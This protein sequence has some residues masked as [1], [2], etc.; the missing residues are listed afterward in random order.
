M[1]IKLPLNKLEKRPS[2][3]IAVGYKELYDDFD[4][5]NPLD[6]IKEI[7]T[8]AIIKFV[9]EHY[10]KGMY[11][12]ADARRQRRD[13]MD[14]RRYL[15]VKSKK[16]LNTYVKQWE[17]QGNHVFL[18]GHEGCMMLYRL[19]LQNNVPL[20]T[21]DDY[22]DLCEDEHEPV[23]KAL[24]YCNQIWTDCQLDE[25]DKAFGVTVR[26]AASMVSASM[27]IPHSRKSGISAL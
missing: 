26:L 5:V 18:F 17:S 15:P 4:T 24:L 14:M 20:D 10:A 23:Y 6:L 13:V 19:A 8:V 22:V 2:L 16:R 1:P 21:D 7:P 3:F 9:A 27:T 25:N 12:L 11:A